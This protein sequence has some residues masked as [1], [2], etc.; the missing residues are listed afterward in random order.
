MSVGSAPNSITEGDGPLSAGVHCPR[1]GRRIAAPGRGWDPHRRLMR[2]VSPSLTDQRHRPSP[3]RRACGLRQSNAAL[4]PQGPTNPRDLTLSG[5]SIVR[6][7]QPLR[8]VLF[9]LS[10]A[11]QAPSAFARIAAESRTGAPSG[12]CNR[13]RIRLGTAIGWRDDVP[14]VDR[15]RVGEPHRA[16]PG[17]HFRRRTAG[18]RSN[19]LSDVSAAASLGCL[20]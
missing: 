2:G 20:G 16:G 10:A 6:A 17:F 11:V 8:R 19:G 7:Q 1:R 3:A 4:P 18:S 15:G 9:L 13:T 14:V 12:C 5:A